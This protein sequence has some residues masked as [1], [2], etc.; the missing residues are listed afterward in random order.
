MVLE[1]GAHRHAVAAD[2][3]GGI[4]VLRPLQQGGGE[5]RR[6]DER[7]QHRQ[8][9]R[10]D[11]GDGELAVNHPGGTAEKGHGQE[12]RREHQG[13]G[14]QCHLDFL[15]GGDGGVAR[16]HPRVFV[17]QPLDVFHHHNG[18]VHQQADG[19]H[20][21]KQ[22]E[23][24]DGIASGGQNA[25]GAQQYH[26]HRDGGNERR[27]PALQEDEHHHDHQCDRLE[28]GDDHVADRFGDEQR[29]VVG[30]VVFIAGREHL[31]LAG[32][33]GLHQLGG[34]KS[35]GAGGQRDAHAGARV[36]VHAAHHRIVFRAQFDA[37]DIRQMHRAAVGQ[38]FHHDAGKFRRRGEAR[39]RGDG[40]VQHLA[41]RIGH[42]AHLARGHF[43]VLRG[44][45]GDDI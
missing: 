21:A 32:E 34:G 15:H 37:G 14:H 36:A 4:L 35:V 30:K 25:E 23:R 22:G 1:G 40:G 9:H 18:I 24:V 5:R 10:R 19:Q 2:K 42:A 11:N 13:D 17:H 8:A 3:A 33:F 12:H 29:G 27:A 39:L 28:Q 31:R 44:K 7:D 6:E 26:R 20:Q 45:G 16:G 41:G 38:R 43:G